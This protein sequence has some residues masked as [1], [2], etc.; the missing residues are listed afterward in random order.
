MCYYKLQ[1]QRI[2]HTSWL[3][4]IWRRSVVYEQDRII[5]NTSISASHALP[6]AL[7]RCPWLAHRH[8]SW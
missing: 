1:T 2:H 3:L 6:R 7:S 5:S 8:A 4:A